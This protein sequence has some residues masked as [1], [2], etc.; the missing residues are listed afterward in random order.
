MVIFWG[1]G[2]DIGKY[3]FSPCHELETK[4]KSESP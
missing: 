4:E 3:V 1:F 2:K